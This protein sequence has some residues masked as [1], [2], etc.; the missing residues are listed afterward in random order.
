[1]VL[2]TS[3][4]EIAGNDPVPVRCTHRCGPRH[5]GGQCVEMHVSLRIRLRARAPW[6]CCEEVHG[7]AAD[8][9]HTVRHLT[10]WEWATGRRHPRG[11]GL[12]GTVRVGAPERVA[13][14]P[15]GLAACIVW[16]ATP[17]VAG[18]AHATNHCHTLH[19]VL[20]HT[21]TH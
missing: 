15:H 3:K 20:C 18:S 11:T 16:N 6:R 5:S 14:D 17:C 9:Q 2:A 21:D 4:T 19:M 7:N 1:M 10:V 13:A 12:V 8:A